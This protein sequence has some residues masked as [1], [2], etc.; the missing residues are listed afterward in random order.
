[1]GKVDKE[2]VD[3]DEG[4]SIVEQLIQKPIQSNYIN[5]KMRSMEA[6]RENALATMGDYF[7]EA[8]T[9]MV[10]LMRNAEKD[11][12][13]YKASAK[14]I[15]YAVGKPTEIKKPDEPKP[16]NLSDEEFE[17]IIDDGDEE[18]MQKIIEGRY[19]KDSKR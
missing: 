9:T 13:R 8:L 5:K 2:R 4:T 19:G 10:D 12:I 11:D 17:E 7:A 18:K 16:I 6:A 1:M 15:E 3:L 14:I